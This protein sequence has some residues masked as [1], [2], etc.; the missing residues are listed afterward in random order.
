MGEKSRVS[1]IIPVYNGEKFIKKAIESALNQT[2]SPDEVI[3]ID[4]A[5]TDKTCE[6]V[7]SLRD[8]RI[9]YFRNEV[10]K[11]RAYTRN[12]GVDIAKGEFIFF[13][14]YDDEWKEDYVESS[15]EY[16][17]EG[18]DVVYSIPRE[19]IDENS[20]VIRVSR[21]P[22]PRDDGEVIFSSLVGYPSATSLR[23]ESFIK[24]ENEYIPREDWELFIRYFLEGKEIKILDNRKVMIREHGERTSNNP[25]FMRSTL[26]LYENYREKI[27][28][29]YIPYFTLHTALICMRFGNLPVGWFLLFKSVLRKPSLLRNSRNIVNALKWGL[30]VD[31]FIK[32]IK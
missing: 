24:Y 14:D 16:L 29:R 17:E 31:R 32:H 15:L 21:K 9:L 23:R 1:V 4:D 28:D 6:V 10:N 22:I 2:I 12:R 19:F 5:S 11:E 26:R 20:E 3:V 25:R 30:R 18:Y 27:P 7:E 8:K 13:L